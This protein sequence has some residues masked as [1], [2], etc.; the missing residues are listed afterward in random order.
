M[1]QF[2]WDR[3]KSFTPAMS[4]PLGQDNYF[5]LHVLPWEPD[6]VMCINAYFQL[7]LGAVFSTH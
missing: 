5:V 1:N 4:G 7:L 3:V 2:S 6:L